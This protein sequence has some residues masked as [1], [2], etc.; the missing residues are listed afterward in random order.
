M[1]GEYAHAVIGQVIM[2]KR[3]SWMAAS[4]SRCVIKEPHQ[5]RS[6]R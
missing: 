5:M 2:E 3:S 6:N 4:S 1:N